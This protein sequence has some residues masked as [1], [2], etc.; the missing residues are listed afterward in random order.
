[1]NEKMK[2]SKIYLF[3]NVFLFIMLI[4][5]LVIS[6]GLSGNTKYLLRVIFR[7][8]LGL[9][10]I[11]NSIYLLLTN[12]W[13]FLT[14]KASKKERLIFGILLGIVGLICVITSL[15]GYGLN[16]NPRIMLW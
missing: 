16:G 15:L 14:I 2:K 12:G 11:Y 9:L 7:G 3:M 1:M 5:I 6:I 13:S 4:L 10:M 8:F